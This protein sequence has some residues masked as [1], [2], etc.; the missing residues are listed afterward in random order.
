MVSDDMSTGSISSARDV[1]GIALSILDEAKKRAAA[2][3]I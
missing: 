2:K 3:S 1:Q